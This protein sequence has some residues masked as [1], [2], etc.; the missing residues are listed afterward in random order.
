MS[1]SNRKLTVE[2]IQAVSAL[3][4]NKELIELLQEI[5]ENTLTEESAK[6][7]LKQQ[8]QKGEDGDDGDDNV[9]P[10]VGF[11]RGDDL[12]GKEGEGE[13][14][15]DEKQAKKGLLRKLVEMGLVLEGIHI[16]RERTPEERKK[17]AAAG[18]AGISRSAEGE[19]TRKFKLTEEGF[20]LLAAKGAAGA[21]NRSRGNNSSSSGS[22]HQESNK[23]REVSSFKQGIKKEDSR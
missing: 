14:Q 19:R 1:T 22:S 15:S 13:E 7:K 6:G 23:A 10:F 8:Q 21:A 2:E 20:S 12:L 9:T 4:N 5:H 17:R 11:T 16:A 18:G 3:L